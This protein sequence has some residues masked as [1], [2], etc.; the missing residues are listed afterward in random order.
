MVDH[1]H[2][3]VGQIPH[4]LV[5]VFALLHQHQFQFIAGVHDDPHGL[6][7]V[8]EIENRQALQLGHAAQVG[9]VG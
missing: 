4:G 5:F 1:D 8:I 2:G 7:E 6:R 3:P 9:V